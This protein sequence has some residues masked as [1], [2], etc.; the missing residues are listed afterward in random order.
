MFYNILNEYLKLQH[1]QN[2]PI[3][4]RYILTLLIFFKQYLIL[5]YN[6]K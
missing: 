5:H 1:E 6:I 3:D 2:V 4:I